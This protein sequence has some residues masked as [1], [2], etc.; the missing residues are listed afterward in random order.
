MAELNLT[1]NEAYAIANHIDLTL[2][3]TIRDD[4]DID[5]LMWLRNMIHGYEKLCAYSGY[6]GMTESEPDTETE[7]KYD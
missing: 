3:H 5:S 4:T 6:K 7:A 1:K 2:I